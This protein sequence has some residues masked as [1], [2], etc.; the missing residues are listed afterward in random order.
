MTIAPTQLHRPRTPHGRLWAV[1]ML[2]L[3]LVVGGAVGILIGSNAFDDSSSPTGI[4]GSG[5]TATET[6]ELPPF[7]SV[8]LAGS[9]IVTIRV[10]NEQ[11]VVVR[12]DDNLVD[13]VTT[14][15]QD[16]SRGIG[17]GP[18]SFTTTSPMTVT[19]GVPS[20]DALTL[21]GSG[22]VAATGVDASSLTVRLPGSGV[23]RASGAA[24]TLD[25]TLE[26]SGDAQLGQ[27]AA[28]DARAVV[29]GSGR[30]VLTA[31]KSLD[32]TVSGSGAIMY[33]GNPQDVEQSVTGSGAIIETAG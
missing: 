24:T 32:A 17:T 20:L 22:I 29:S 8:E 4:Q 25:V 13:R 26:G 7:G 9:T 33:G 23:L 31:T 5:V 6:R 16:G 28:D 18:G 1:A 10:G 30:I 11:S 19:V 21:S 27:L 15:V 14:T 12:A 3:G 2:L